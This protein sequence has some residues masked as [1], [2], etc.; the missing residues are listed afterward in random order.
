M[1]CGVAVV[2]TVAPLA[3]CGATGGGSA[4][5]GDKAGGSNSAELVVLRML[6]PAAGQL[7]RNFVNEVAK[8]SNGR[9]RIDVTD[10][11]HFGGPNS[12]T[13]AHDL[14]GAV[15]AGEAPLGLAGASAFQEQGVRSFDALLAPLLVDRNELQT[16]VLHSDIASDMLAGTEGAGVTGIGILPGPISYPWGADRHLLDVSDYQGGGFIGPGRPITKRSI[17]ALGG[18]FRT[19]TSEADQNSAPVDGFVV[20]AVERVGNPNGATSVTTNVTFG[21]FA[22]VVI[23]NEGAIAVLSERDRSVLREAARATI[24]IDA[25]TVS[26][27]EAQSVGELCRGGEVAFDRASPAQVNAL[28]A[29]LEPVYQ[30]LRE[31][32]ATSDFIDR[33]QRMSESAPAD[34]G[35]ATD[36]GCPQSAQNS[37]APAAAT[38]ID[39]TY[40]VTTTLDDLKAS[41]APP[42][43]WVPEHWGES[44]YVFDR[45]RF[46][47]TQHNDEACTWAYGRF[48]VDGDLLTLNFDDGGGLAPNDRAPRPGQHFGVGWSLYRDVLTLSPKDGEPAPMVSGHTWPLQRVGA[49]PDVSAL[50][51]QCPP[52]AR[53]FPS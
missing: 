41:G 33:I 7:S 11:W 8:Q 19:P 27:A 49:T 23:G 26:S 45:G 35:G 43:D 50:N 52:P 34:P 20:P 2:V 5:A 32:P 9:I 17:E 18:A 42:D 47:T 53:A 51:Q 44:V 36:I 15:R 28:R 3:G 24:D 10:L 21:P 29:K 38:P 37:A 13:R 22:E 40:S 48:A 16:A 30:W 46:A 12:A 1:L 4:A 31:D 14:I 25:G 39:G 6:N